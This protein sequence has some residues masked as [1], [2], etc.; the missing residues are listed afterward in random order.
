MS[1][2]SLSVLCQFI[3]GGDSVCLLSVFSAGGE[4]GVQVIIVHY[5]VENE[6]DFF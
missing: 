6:V 2:P 1:C 3:G 4:G 5:L